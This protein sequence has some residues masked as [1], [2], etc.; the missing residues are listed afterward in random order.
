MHS[1]ARRFRLRLPSALFEKAAAAAAAEKI[2]VSAFIQRLV[3]EDLR[4]ENAR[5][6]RAKKT[7]RSR[8]P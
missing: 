8:R 5:R 7:R 6:R 4:P 2:G 3:Q 1:P